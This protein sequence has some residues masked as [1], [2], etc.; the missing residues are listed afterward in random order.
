MMIFA[1]GMV[2]MLPKDYLD[3]LKG[4]GRSRGI[5]ITLLAGDAHASGKAMRI[6]DHIS[7]KAGI[8]TFSEFS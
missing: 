3:K 6:L 7:R 4:I 2:H 8:K 5:P 1:T